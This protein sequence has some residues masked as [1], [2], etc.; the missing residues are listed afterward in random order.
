MQTTNR[1]VA[2]NITYSVRNS[3]LFRLRFQFFAIQTHQDLLNEGQSVNRFPWAVQMQRVNPNNNVNASVH[4]GI[5]LFTPSSS[6]TVAALAGVTLTGLVQ[7]TFTAVTSATGV[8]MIICLLH[9][10]CLQEVRVPF[11]QVYRVGTQDR[12]TF[13]A[14]IWKLHAACLISFPCVLPFFSTAAKPTVYGV[15]LSRSAWNWLRRP[16]SAIP[17]TSAQTC[18][19]IWRPGCRKSFTNGSAWMI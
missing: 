16:T 9:I 10:L 11:T 12:Q 3:S 6:T 1:T 17:W 15:R 5:S 2:R 19:S 13:H 4:M 18:D 8:W 7:H 14:N